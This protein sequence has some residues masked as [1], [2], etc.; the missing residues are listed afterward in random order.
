MPRL[1]QAEYERLRAETVYGFTLNENTGECV[2]FNRDYQRLPNEPIP[3]L[4]HEMKGKAEVREP[5]VV[6]AEHRQTLS[7]EKQKSWTTYYMFTDR[8]A[9]W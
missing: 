2:C 5:G 8:T 3:S 1:S 7:P 6:L 9:P 4:I